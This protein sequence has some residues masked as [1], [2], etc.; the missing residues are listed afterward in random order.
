MIS[1]DHSKFLVGNYAQPAIEIVRGK[2]TKVWDSEGKEYL[3][4]TTGIAVTNLGH[5]HP[6]WIHSVTD[7]ANEM[8]HCSDLFSIPEQVRLAKRLVEK[9]GPGKLIFCNSG[10]EANE[11]LLKLARLSLI[12]I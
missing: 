12:H 5:S 8:V 7:Q 6:H 1:S 11:G 4:F 3:D 2:G 9:I 10:A